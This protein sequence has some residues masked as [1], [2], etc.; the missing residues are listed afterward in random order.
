M[1]SG[2]RA[3]SPARDRQGEKKKK[4][5]EKKM[6]RFVPAADN[7]SFIQPFSE[8]DIKVSKWAN[9][10][11]FGRELFT[12]QFL[13]CLAFFPLA[14]LLFFYDSSGVIISYRSYSLIVQLLRVTRVDEL[15]SISTNRER[16]NVFFSTGK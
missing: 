11:I 14:F 3:K 16:R 8:W 5:K 2:E 6:I 10:T 9:N 4:R 12:A 1:S 7:Y 13:H 15:Q